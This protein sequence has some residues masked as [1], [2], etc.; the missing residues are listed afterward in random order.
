MRVKLTCSSRIMHVYLRA[1]HAAEPQKTSRFTAQNSRGPPVWIAPLCRKEIQIHN[2][3][4]P[5]RLCHFSLKIITCFLGLARRVKFMKIVIY[6]GLERYLGYIFQFEA[7][8]GAGPSPRTTLDVMAED[9][10]APLVYLTVILAIL[11]VV[12]VLG[13]MAATW[14]CIKHYRLLKPVP[15]IS[16]I[17]LDRL[18]S[19]LSRQVRGGAM[20]R[21]V[22]DEPRGYQTPNGVIPN[23]SARGGPDAG[24]AAARAMEDGEADYVQLREQAGPEEF[25][26]LLLRD[27]LDLGGEPIPGKGG[28]HRKASADSASSSGVCSDREPDSPTSDVGAYSKFAKLYVQLPAPGSP[29]PQGPAHSGPGQPRLDSTDSGFSENGTEC[30]V[31]SYT[32]LSTIPSDPGMDGVH[33]P[34]SDYNSGALYHGI[35]DDGLVTSNQHPLQDHC[36]NRTVPSYTRLSSIPAPVINSVMPSFGCEGHLTISDGTVPVLESV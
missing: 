34:E 28:A 27:D 1:I 12:L 10:P 33:L 9:K 5:W 11:G 20:E 31:P 15:R 7:F 2:N 36:S 13:I 17:A 35:A 24:G 18:E 25:F 26:P 30:R 23:G 14:C 16:I 8:N 19:A 6:T 3:S 32:K 22:F 4:E 21:E 29:H